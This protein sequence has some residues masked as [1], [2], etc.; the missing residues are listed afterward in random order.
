MKLIGKCFYHKREAQGKCIEMDEQLNAI[1]GY[2]NGNLVCY[3]SKNMNSVWE[4][5]GH[6]GAV[7]TIFCGE[8][9]FLSGGEDCVVRIWSNGSR[10]LINQISVHQ[11]TVSKVLG[12]FKYPHIIHSCS[13]DRSIH[14]YDLKSDKKLSFRQAVGGSINSMS[15]SSSSGE[16]GNSYIIQ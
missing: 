4:I 6:K 15:Q 13:I 3:S 5:N 10:Q 16:L 9:Y 12:D 14:A 7:S 1:A 11:K 2:S 8:S